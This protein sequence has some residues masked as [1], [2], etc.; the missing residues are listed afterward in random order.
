MRR[1]GVMADAFKVEGPY[2][3]KALSEIDRAADLFYRSMVTG[4]R[5]APGLA[6]MRFFN[7]IRMKVKIHR[8]KLPFDYRYWEDKGWFSA[9][10]FY[11]ARL[12][13]IFVLLGKLPARIIMP[14][15]RI[16][17]GNSLYRELVRQR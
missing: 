6:E 10:Y 12:N 14:A 13:P 15:L 3:E 9:G 1:L 8:D 11:P 2:R 4:R 16:K 7:A 17:P 5:P